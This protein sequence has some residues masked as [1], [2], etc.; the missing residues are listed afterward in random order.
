MLSTLVCS[1]HSWGAAA[2][3][4]KYIAKSAAKNISS[5]ESHTIVPTLTMLG[6]VSEWIWLL[7]IAGAAVTASLLPP[8]KPL[9]TLGRVVALDVGSLRVSGP[10]SGGWRRTRAPHRKLRFEPALLVD[11]P[12]FAARGRFLPGRRGEA[13]QAWR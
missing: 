5:L 11:G 6:R 1:A 4:E 13:A 12:V 8:I 2:R 7:A 9:V 3:I 10:N